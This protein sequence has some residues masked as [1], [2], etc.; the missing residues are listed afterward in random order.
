MTNKSPEHSVRDARHLRQHRRRPHHHRTQPHLRRYPRLRGHGM[1][2]RIIPVLIYGETFAWHAFTSRLLQQEHHRP[3]K[4]EP[5]P[6]RRLT[7]PTLASAY[8]AAV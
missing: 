8:F 3:N 5:P 7:R 6:R 1:L 4:H 2:H